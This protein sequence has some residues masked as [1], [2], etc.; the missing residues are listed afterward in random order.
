M[1]PILGRYFVDDEIWGFREHGLVR[2]RDAAGRRYLVSIFP[3]YAQRLSSVRADTERYECA[4]IARLVDAVSDHRGSDILVEE[5]PP[6]RPSYE[7]P[8]RSPSAARELAI[9]L[10][11]IVAVAGPG[12]S[13]I[14]PELVYVHRGDGEHDRVT[15]APRYMTMGAHGDPTRTGGLPLFPI[16]WIS[17]EQARNASLTEA[18]DSYVLASML[19]FW[20]TASPLIVPGENVIETLLRVVQHDYYFHYEGP[21]H[22]VVDAGLAGEPIAKLRQRLERAD[23]ASADAD[24]ATRAALIADIVANPD[25]DGPRFVLADHLLERGDPRG[26]LIQLQCRGRPVETILAKYGVAWSAYLRDHVREAFF[27]RGFV[28]LVRGARRATL[29][30]HREQLLA[31]GPLPRVDE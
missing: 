22:D 18:H 24:H 29:E 3:H 6:G 30:R 4:G 26:E 25:D 1:E 12:I 8:P 21:L 10:A 2:A 13:G 19:R 28:A 27:D 16:Q 15:I 14:R 9:D 17:S 7:L 11:R 31:F 23:L 20:L 5:E